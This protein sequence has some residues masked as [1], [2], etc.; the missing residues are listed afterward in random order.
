MMGTTIMET[1]RLVVLG[2][3]LPPDAFGVMAMILVIIGFGQ[4]FSQMGL[5]QA[6][7]QRPVPQNKELVSLYWLNLATGLFV[8]ALL[9]LSTPLVVKLYSSPALKPLIPFVGLMFVFNALGDLYR[10]TLEKKLRFKP[11][12]IIELTGAFVGMV[13]SVAFAFEGY[14]VWSL[15]WGQLAMSAFRNLGFFLR[16]QALFRP[17]FHFALSD[18]RGYLSFGLHETG[19]MSLS[20]FNSR[21]D[22]LLIGALLGPQALGY[23]S[24]AVNLIMRPVQKINPVLT[25]VAFPIL[26]QVQDDNQR[27]KRGYFKMLGMLSSVNAPLLIGLAVVAPVAVPVVLG[28]KW[29]PIIPIVQILTLFSLLRS[30]GNAGGSMLLAKGRADIS[31]YWNILLFCFMPGVIF[32]AAFYGDLTTVAWALFGLQFVLLFV[33]YALIVRR[34]LGSCLKGYLSS[35]MTPFILAAVMGCAVLLVSYVWPVP[36][37]LLA[38]VLQIVIGAL[39]YCGLYALF[40]RNSM[41]EIMR[42]ALN[43]T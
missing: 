24:M 1:I 39:V 23:Y 17:G 33:W 22:Q 34:L 19:A 25:R 9:L 41:L 28:P 29:N 8:Y 32:V 31:L 43:R 40:A 13:V 20:Y 2:R 3:V 26:A 10:A 38:L 18:L 16:G 14:E 37:G 30:L 5:A 35:F 6:V 36:P 15:V 4:V 27:M 21:I 42:L 7:I 12:A 11:L